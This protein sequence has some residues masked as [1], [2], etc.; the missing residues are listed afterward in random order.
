MS[1]S[2]A[3]AYAGVTGGRRAIGLGSLGTRRQR[4][5]FGVLGLISLTLPYAVMLGGVIRAQ[6]DAPAATVSL[7][8]LTLPSVRIPPIAVPKLRRP[9][10]GAATGAAPQAHQAGVTHTRYVH[11]VTTRQVRTG[12]AG[13]VRRVLVQRH[14]PV[15]T[16]SYS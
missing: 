5:W 9:P 2:L 12:H 16:S 14:V 13:T 4:F 11:R 3:P 8:A 6:F 10:A 1:R 7:P 15:I